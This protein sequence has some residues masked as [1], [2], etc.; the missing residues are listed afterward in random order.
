MVG[1]NSFSRDDKYK[2]FDVSYMPAVGIMVCKDMAL[3]FGIGGVAYEWTKSDYSTQG[4]PAGTEMSAKNSDFE[5]TLGRQFN[6]GIQKCFGGHRK[7]RRAADP[8]DETR[9]IDTTDDTEETD[10]NRRRRTRRDDE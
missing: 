7:V 5:I 3:S 10:G 6:V 4:Y 1:G 9:H 2:G 8:M